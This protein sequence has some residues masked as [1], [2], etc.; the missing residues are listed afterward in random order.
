MIPRMATTLSTTPRLPESDQGQV[1]AEG[2]PEWCWSAL[3]E[4][5][6]LDDDDPVRRYPEDAAIEP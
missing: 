3:G 2:R 6:V 5:P 4:T 1:R